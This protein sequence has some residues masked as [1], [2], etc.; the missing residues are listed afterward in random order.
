MMKKQKSR[1]NGAISLDTVMHVARL[2]RI[3]LTPAAAK[4]YQ[5]ELNEI[6]LAFRELDKAKANV[7]PS[8]H[9]IDVKDVL[10]KDEPEQSLTREQA[11]ANTK[12]KED[13][14]FKGPRAV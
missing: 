8:F 6:I 3:N 1:K 2:A 5:K 12:H 7:K 4:K 9:P 13:G 14:F 11:L 10:R